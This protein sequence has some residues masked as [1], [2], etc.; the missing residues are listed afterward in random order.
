M[1]QSIQSTSPEPVRILKSAACPSLSGKSKLSYEV[2]CDENSAIK[3]RIV[4]NTASGSFNREWIDLQAIRST[5]EKVPRDHAITSNALGSLFRGKSVNNQLF[6]FAILVHE[7]LVHRSE[8]EKRGYERVEV[9]EFLKRTQAFLN[10][11]GMA[12]VGE[13]RNMKAK[14]KSGTPAKRPTAS[15]K[16]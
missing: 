6:L 15:R 9:G 2:G 14:T 13:S 4:A 3:L 5:L 11:K 10:G 16:K 7:G 1:K 12:A 8:G